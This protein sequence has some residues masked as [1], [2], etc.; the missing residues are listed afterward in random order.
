MSRQSNGQTNRR[1]GLTLIELVVVVVILVA[2]AGILIPMLPNMLTRAHTATGATNT[3]EVAKF[4]QTHQQLFQ[5][6]PA[7]FDALV[8]ATGNLADYLPGGN[9][10]G[11]ITPLQLTAAQRNALANAGITRLAAMYATRAA[12]EAAGGTPTFN[13][14]TGGT[15][16]LTT[17]TPS[18]ARVSEAAVETIA[19]VVRDEPANTGDVYVIV[20]LGQRCTM[21]GK[22]VQEAPVHF[23]E[24]TAGNAANVYGRYCAIFRVTRGGATPTDLETAILVGVV[25]LHDDGIATGNMHL[26]EYYKATKSQ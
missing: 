18:V 11:Q 6:Y 14:Y 21:I 24:N 12:L 2:L 1:K 25:A 17:G 8:D 3:G 23:G 20:G 10:G 15:I 13:P 9:V 7:D 22:T 16:D 4:L 5:S 19:G 26:E